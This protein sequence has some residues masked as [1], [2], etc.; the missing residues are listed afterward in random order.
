M[1]AGTGD[2]EPGHASTLARRA[3][4][5]RPFASRFSWGLVD[6]A[7]ASFTNFVLGLFIARSVT[8]DEFGAFSLALVT[9]WT[10]LALARAVTS[11]PLVIR[12]SYVDETEWRHAVEAAT[13]S[14]ASIGLGLGAVCLITSLILPQPTRDAFLGLGLILPVLLTQDCWRFCFMAAGRARAAL[15]NDII[16]AAVLVT[17]L[18]IFALMGTVPM[19][20]AF[21]IW[22]L[23]AAAA[24]GSGWKQSG[25]RPAPRNGA[26]WIRTHHDLASRFAGE[27][28]TSMGSTQLST[29]AVAG[30]GG[31]AVAGS[32]RAGQLLLSPLHVLYQG[33]HLIGIPEG[34]RA[35]RQTEGRFLLLLGTLSVGLAIVV[36]G[37]AV[38][39]AVMPVEAGKAVLRQQ[40]LPAQQVL[41]PLAV[42][43]VLQALAVGPMIGLR[44]MAAADRSLRVTIAA[45]ITGTVASIIGVLLAG[46]VGVAWALAATS[47]AALVLWTREL[48]NAMAAHRA[49]TT[50]N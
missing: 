14:A 5:L 48:R 49:D 42:N 6:Q 31:L 47:A 36:A 29:Y 8:T 25:I 18:A 10:A 19:V 39:L 16:L 22:G 46:A 27:A 50:G 24:V 35:L 3:R 45:A 7:L 37:W 15:I 1:A 17:L 33:I 21:V 2:G 4:S 41:M 30:L 38:A 28:A 32:L 20:G 40:W 9:Y 26:K 34:A 44:V 43:F 12:F 11:Q 13:G 23:A